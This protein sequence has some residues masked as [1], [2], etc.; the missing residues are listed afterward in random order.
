VFA[1]SL[2]RNTE[3]ATYSS[4]TFRVKRLVHCHYF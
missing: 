1:I 3:L 2:K 4:N